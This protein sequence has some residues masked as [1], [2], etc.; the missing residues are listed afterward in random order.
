MVNLND[1]AAASAAAQQQ[2]Q[3]A[4]HEGHGSAQQA[5]ASQAALAQALQMN[6]FLAAQ[7]QQQ[8]AL[9]FSAAFDS[10]QKEAPDEN[11]RRGQMRSR[12]RWQS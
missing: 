11:Q 5:A 12:P 2:Q 4:Q 8:A 6:P 10:N 1:P 7:A 9:A 3:Q